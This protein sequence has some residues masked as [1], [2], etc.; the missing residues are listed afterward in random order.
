VGAC[1]C[2]RAVG[3]QSGDVAEQTN[4]TNT[5][6][7]LSPRVI[8]QCKT[9]SYPAIDRVLSQAR[10][11]NHSHTPVAPSDMEPVPSRDSSHSAA[12]P[13]S[14]S[15]SSS[16][17]RDGEREV[18]LEKR[19]ENRHERGGAAGVTEAGGTRVG[20][21]RERGERRN[22]GRPY[23]PAEQGVADQVASIKVCTPNEISPPYS[24]LA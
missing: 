1:F 18:N 9:K 2:V 7:S 19:S 16:S 6:T 14:P 21:E 17:A 13:A 22:R 12:N 20:A 24:N 15:C 4:S 8:E 23:T 5:Q 3:H 11:R 10:K